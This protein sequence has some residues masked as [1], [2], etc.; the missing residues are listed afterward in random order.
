M[1]ARSMP[2]FQLDERI[3]FPPPE[4]ADPDGLLAVGGDLRAERLLLAYAS[5]I[6]PWPADGYPLLW[7]SP[8]PRYVLPS[9]ELHVP[10]SLRRVLN[11]GA[12]RV[13]LDTEFAAVMRACA[14]VPRLGQ[15]GTWITAEMIDAYVELHRLGFAHS[16][17][18]WEGDARVPCGG[19]YGVSLGGAFFGESMFAKKPD[20]SKV[21]FVTF[22]EQ[23]ARWGVR[24]VDAQV[25][26]AHLERFGARFWPR[27]R[28]LGELGL[29]LEQPTRRGK[30]RFDSAA[31]T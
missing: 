20:A 18:V 26:T 29:L 3:V 15:R 9:D 2:I 28:Y 27:E 5:G 8:D 11:R 10:R 30:W 31:A 25:H 24:L 21:G 17:E 4:L 19:L 16:V 13:T 6:F 1:L 12:Y 23:L 14:K 22:V 7:H